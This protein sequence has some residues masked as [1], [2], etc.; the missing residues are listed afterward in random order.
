MTKAMYV[1][2]IVCFLFFILCMSIFE[3]IMLD[4]ILVTF[5]NKT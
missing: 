5:V 3:K 1:C 2:G 4:N